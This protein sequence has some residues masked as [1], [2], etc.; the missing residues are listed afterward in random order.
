MSKL[1]Q[2]KDIA[3]EKLRKEKELNIQYQEQINKLI[4]KPMDKLEQREEGEM[5]K[6]N[7]IDQ[8]E[9]EINGRNEREQ[10]LQDQLFDAEKGLLE[11]KFEKETYDLQYARL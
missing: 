10:E 8:L 11:L 5:W 9:E 2:E 4:G 7:R 1:T 3:E 6:Q